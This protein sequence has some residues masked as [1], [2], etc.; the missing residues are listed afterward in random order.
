MTIK[1]LRE[2]KTIFSV[3]EFVK[4]ELG[5]KFT[6]SPSFDLNA[7]Y[8]DSSS[9]SPIIF[10][11]S[12]GADPLIYLSALAREKE[13]EGGR[14]KLLALG[15]GQGGIAKRYIEEGQ[16]NG[17]WVVLQN[18]HLA[19][20]WMPTLERIQEQQVEAD[21]HEEYRLWLTSMPSPNFPVPVLQNGIKMTN[22]P[23]RGLKAN[24]E[25]TF[26]EISSK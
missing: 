25:R 24:L 12:P 2:E 14:M 13:M 26:N 9:T 3:K 22:E 20:T 21:T 1:T 11:L 5:A 19:I 10:V 8:E 16:R 23:P 15:Q 17:D 7:A 6:Q 4:A 18:C